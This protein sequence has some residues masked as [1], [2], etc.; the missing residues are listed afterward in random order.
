[1]YIERQYPCSKYIAHFK[2]EEKNSLLN[3]TAVLQKFIC[4]SC[5]S[6]SY[7]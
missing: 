1:M 3:N 5:Y 4:S 2:Y 6:H 7:F